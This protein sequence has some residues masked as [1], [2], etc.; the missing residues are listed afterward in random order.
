MIPNRDHEW[1]Q[2]D[3]ANINCKPATMFGA[4]GMGQ[5]T[6]DELAKVKQKENK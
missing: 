6:L 3:P 4:P 1:T 5:L 2:P